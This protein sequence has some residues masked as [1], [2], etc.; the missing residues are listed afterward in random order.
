[1]IPLP[2]FVGKDK[3]LD[4]EAMDLAA[5]LAS[6]DYISCHVPETLDQTHVQYSRD[7]PQ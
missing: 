2:K 3:A 4:A 7:S 5:L 1:M 6:A